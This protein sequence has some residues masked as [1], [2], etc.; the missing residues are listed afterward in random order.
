MMRVQ[1]ATGGTVTSKWHSLYCRDD[2]SSRR[3]G[4]IA[5]ALGGGVKGTSEGF[6]DIRDLPLDPILQVS[7]PQWSRR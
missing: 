7:G 3:D 4:G 6:A 1:P 5:G 2:V